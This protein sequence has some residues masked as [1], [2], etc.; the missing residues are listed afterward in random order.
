MGWGGGGGGG[1]EANLKL[2]N[3]ECPLYILL[4]TKLF[5]Y[6]EKNFRT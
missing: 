1:G 6:Y 2:R 3:D 4:L 5:F